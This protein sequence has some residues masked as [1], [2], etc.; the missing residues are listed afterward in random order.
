M[1]ALTVDHERCFRLLHG[2]TNGNDAPLIPDEGP[3]GDLR[4]GGRMNAGVDKDNGLG[5]EC[6]QEAEKDHDLEKKGRI[7]NTK[8]GPKCEIPPDVTTRLGALPFSPFTTTT[9]GGLSFALRVI[10]S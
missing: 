10:I 5:G 3:V 1:F 8:V 6:A 2:C 7:H 4:S 9:K